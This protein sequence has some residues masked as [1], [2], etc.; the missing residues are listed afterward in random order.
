MVP[1]SSWAGGPWEHLQGRY[2]AASTLTAFEKAE[3]A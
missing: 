1:E 3:S 2:A